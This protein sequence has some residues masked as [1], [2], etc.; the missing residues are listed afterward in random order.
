MKNREATLRNTLGAIVGSILLVGCAANVP[1]APTAAAPNP[2]PT[3]ASISTSTASTPTV[4]LA[5]P[6]AAATS[7]VP[8]PGPTPPSTTRPPVSRTPASISSEPTIV[9]TG[10]VREVAASARVIDLAEGMHG[11]SEVA[12]NDDTGITGADGASKSLQDIQPGVLIQ[13]AGW[14][15]GSGGV[16]AKSIRILTGPSPMPLQSGR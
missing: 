7:T 13:V 11:F 4:L 10:Q 14:A 16:I 12:L 2:R 6:T 5:I 1:A 8:V 9:I 15:N 3:A